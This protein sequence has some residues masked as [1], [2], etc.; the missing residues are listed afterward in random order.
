MS[1]FL[2][3]ATRDGVVLAADKRTWDPLRGVRDDQ[4]KVVRLGTHTALATTGLPR[5]E[6]AL[7]VP[8]EPPAFALLYD[9]AEV[10]REYY[11][12]AD[13]LFPES[14]QGLAERLRSA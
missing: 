9:A 2:A 1:L 11:G 7:H 10:I 5:F 14:Q 4:E 8:P 13:P 12:G 6:T 3:T